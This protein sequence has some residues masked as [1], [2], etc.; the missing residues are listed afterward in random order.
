MELKNCRNC[1]RLFNYITG[2][3]LCGGCKNKLEEVF[4]VVKQYIR[5]NPG[6]NVE[7]VA[8]ACE[9]SPRQ[10]RRWVREERLTFSDDSLVGLEAFRW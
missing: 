5:D 7:Q 6:S 2:E 8:E 1:K 9:V 4:V 10:I 3:P